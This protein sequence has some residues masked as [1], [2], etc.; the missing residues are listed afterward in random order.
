MFRVIVS[1][2]VKVAIKPGYPLGYPG[3]YLHIKGEIRLTEPAR[4]YRAYPHGRSF[5]FP[6]VDFPC[7]RDIISG[8][9]CI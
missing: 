1:I 4:G 6:D 7:C 2:T 5:I 3:F 9:R 8:R